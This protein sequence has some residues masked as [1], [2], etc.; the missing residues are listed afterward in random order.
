MAKWFGTIGYAKQVETEP[1]YWEE[2]IT[3]R[4]YYGDIIRNT[5]ALQ[6]TSQ[7]NDDVN[8]GNQIS[9]LADPYAVNHIYAMRCIEFQ[10]ADWT[11]SNVDVQYPRLIL[12]IGGLYKDGK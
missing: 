9:I 8:I 2:K 7:I 10:G 11:V 6:N 1:G 12:S 4:P 5:R 3:K